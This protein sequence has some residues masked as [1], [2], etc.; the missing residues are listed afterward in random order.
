MKG[1]GNPISKI[2]IAIAL[3]E[4]LGFDTSTE[5]QFGQINF[6]VSPVMVDLW[7]DAYNF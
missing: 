6:E 7:F 4:N 3:F 2:D 5:P 1:R